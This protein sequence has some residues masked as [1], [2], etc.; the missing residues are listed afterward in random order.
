MDRASNIWFLIAKCTKLHR[1]REGKNDEN[2]I[3]MKIKNHNKHK[4]KQKQKY[5]RTTTTKIS[6]LSAHTKKKHHTLLTLK[7]CAI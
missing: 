4:P 5:V 1:E 7:L 3:Y 2:E 6:Q